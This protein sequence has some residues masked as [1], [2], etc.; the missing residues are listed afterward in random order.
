MKSVI[1][2]I[3]SFLLIFLIL[4]LMLSLSGLDFLTAISGAASA[5]GNVGPGIGDVGPSETY[6]SIPTTGKYILCGLMFLGRLEMLTIF[7]L[8]LPITIFHVDKHLYSSYII[9]IFWSVE[10][11]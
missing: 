8:F 10:N 9:I 1:T 3:F 4:A 7:I 5:I 2:F 11:L 6:S